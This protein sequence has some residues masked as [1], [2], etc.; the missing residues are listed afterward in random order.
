MTVASDA[1]ELERALHAF[2]VREA[3]L[4]DDMQ[5]DEWEALFADDG[6]YWLPASV[7]ASDPLREAAHLYDDRLLRQV[8][9]ERLR[10]AHAHSQ[11]S[12]GRSHHLLQSPEV[13]EANEADNCYRLRTSFVYTELRGGRTVSLPGV[14]H[15]RLRRSSAGFLIVLKRVDLLHAAEPLPAIE[16]YI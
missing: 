2:V 3:R 11:Q 1:F 5:L 16:F 14:A 10:S 13:L 12:P 4:L 7:G 9:I 8:H 15:H 6:H